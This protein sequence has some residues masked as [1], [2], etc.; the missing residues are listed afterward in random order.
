MSSDG[1]NTRAGRQGDEREHERRHGRR[2]AVPARGRRDGSVLIVVCGLPGVGKTSVAERVATRAEGTLLRTDVVRKERYPDPDYTSEETD[3][4]YADLLDRAESLLEAG[5]TVVLDGTFRRERRRE[6]AKRIAADADAEFRL[7][8]VEC[9]EA[10]VR[11]RIANRTDD[12]SDADFEVHRLLREEFDPV[13]VG[14]ATVDNSG[15]PEE[16]TARVDGLFPTP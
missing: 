13:A 4:V 7:L 6:D 10:V 12:E 5:D 3:A 16:T 15:A 14:H 1:R 9:D 2:S 11:E 8:K